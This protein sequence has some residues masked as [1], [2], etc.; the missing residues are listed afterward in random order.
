MTDG[1]TP[2]ERFAHRVRSGVITIPAISFGRTMRRIA[3]RPFSDNEKLPSDVRSVLIIA[4]EHLGDLIISAGFFRDVRLAFPSARITLLVDSRMKSY[5]LLCPHVDEVLGFE[6]SGG[7]LY[8]VTAGPLCA[9]KFARRELWTRNFDVALN[10]RWDVDSVHGALLGLFSH[11]KFHFGYSNTSNVRKRVVN[12]WANGA[13]SHLIHSSDLTHESDRGPA[14]LR[15]LELPSRDPAS[16]LWFTPEDDRFAREEIRRANARPLIALG[17]GASQAKR[18]WPIDRFQVVAEALLDV[19]RDARFLV[20]GDREDA[21]AAEMLR[22]ALGDRLLNY[23]GTCK[24]SRSGALLSRCDLYLGND[25]GPMHM[26][27]AAGVPVVE[28]SC[29]PVTGARDHANSPDRY[30]PLAVP[31]A[32]LRPLDFTSP[33]SY[34]CSGKSAHCILQVTARDALEA[35]QALIQQR[36]ST[37]DISRADTA[38]HPGYSTNIA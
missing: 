9:F 36:L 37:F 11:A 34:A 15:H 27:A 4:L 13:Y 5:A 38:F 21:K 23:A 26:A 33:C 20:V 32:I 16:K 6:E 3:G 19:W 28:L 22:L 29:H 12:R 17:L 2:L 1:F 25:S 7:K 10:P 14:L 35:A 30:Y 18:R 31:H 8:R 24:I